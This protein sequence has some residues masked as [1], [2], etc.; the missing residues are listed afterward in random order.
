VNKNTR[1]TLGFSEYIFLPKTSYSL[2]KTSTIFCLA[3]RIEGIKPDIDVKKTA[4][5]KVIASSCQG[6]AGVNSLILNCA[7]FSFHS[8]LEFIRVITTALIIL[9]VPIANRIPNSQ[10]ITPRNMLSRRKITNISLSLPPKDFMIPISLRLSSTEIVMTLTIPNMAEIKT[11]KP[12]PA[13]K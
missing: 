11:I 5:P 4:S 10:P 12:N 13:R 1:R 2:L 8:A 9:P 7:R 3:A 6:K